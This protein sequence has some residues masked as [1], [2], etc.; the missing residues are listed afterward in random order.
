MP[1]WDDEHSVR[2]EKER[3]VMRPKMQSGG[4]SLYLTVF[5]HTS[6]RLLCRVH[7]PCA[8]RL[9]REEGHVLPLSS[10]SGHGSPLSLQIAV[11]TEKF[12]TNSGPSP[13][14]NERRGVLHLFRNISHSSLPNPNSRSILIFIV[15]IPNYPSFDDFIRFFGSSI[16]HVSELLFIR[17]QG[18]EDPYSVLIRLVDQCAADGFYCNF[19]GKKFSPYEVMNCQ[20]AEVAGTLPA[21]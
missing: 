14:F 15:A 13:K 8:L 2:S 12:N 6:F 21:V 10:L 16:G 17:N 20:S 3:L 18:M 4:L 7:W 1:E 5:F 9:D 19:N 11:A